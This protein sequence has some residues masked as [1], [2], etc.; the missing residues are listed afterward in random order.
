M[1][2]L[3]RLTKEDL[4]QKL[5]GKGLSRLLMSMR[6]QVNPVQADPVYAV[7]WSMLNIV[8]TNKF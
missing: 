1:R 3:V 5:A 2:N 4:K 7:K 8:K 6:H